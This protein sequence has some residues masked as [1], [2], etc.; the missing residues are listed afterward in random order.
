MQ[1]R[2]DIDNDTLETPVPAI[3]KLL[4]FQWLFPHCAHYDA[5]VMGQRNLL[6]YFDKFIAKEWK[7]ALRSRN[8]ATLQQCD[9]LQAE[10]HKVTGTAPVL[11]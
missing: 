6:C 11:K 4:C 10:Y 9:E 7:V 2:K 5:T 3:K 1:Y 8:T